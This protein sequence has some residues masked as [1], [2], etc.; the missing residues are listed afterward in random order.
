MK[1]SVM[2]GSFVV[3]LY[4]LCLHFISDAHSTTCDQWRLHE[5]LTKSIHSPVFAKKGIRYYI[6]KISFFSDSNA[7]KDLNSV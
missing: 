5:E 7:H 1:A 2:W 4:F 3:G 6:L